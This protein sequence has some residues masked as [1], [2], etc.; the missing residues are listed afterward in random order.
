MNSLSL[1]ITDFSLDTVLLPSPW[2]MRLALHGLWAIVLACAAMLLASRLS[3]G[4]RWT[5]GWLVMLWVAW[6]G[7]VSP[8]YWLGLAF[9]APSLMSAA[10][11]L[12]LVW[13]R[14]RQTCS[15]AGEGLLSLFHRSR[16]LLA[17][18]SV[19]GWLLMLDTLAV[20]PVS[21]YAWGF[22]SLALGTV[23][24]L[25]AL[26]WVIQGNSSNDAD[27][28]W[29]LGI[30]G[31]GLVLLVL[32]LFVVTRLPTG[33]L[34]DSLMDPWLWLALHLVWLVSARRRWRRAA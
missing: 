15:Q 13:C 22:G 11:C 14:E 32:T 28:S 20:S 2:I 12:V 9:Q 4:R 29:T 24:G 26:A 18:G 7:A 6:P 16:L 17:S 19:L 31:F 5:V 10:L 34:W 23:A 30:A 21:F 1:P 8:A 3:R 27:G 25:V 33:N